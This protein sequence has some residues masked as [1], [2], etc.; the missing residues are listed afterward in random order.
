[1]SGPITLFTTLKPVVGHDAVT[2]RNA[3]ESWLALGSGRVRVIVMGGG[4]GVAELC[5]ELGVEH[6]EGV[7]VN[8]YGTPLLSGL[9]D[10]AEAQT[11]RGGVLC[12]LNADIALLP[13]FV[14]AVGRVGRAKKRYLMVGRRTNVRVSAE[15]TPDELE[16]LAKGAGSVDGPT[17]IDYFVTPKG[18]WGRLP[19]FAIGR[20]AWDNWMIYRARCLKM[21]VVDAT[22]CVLAIHQEHDYEHTDVEDGRGRKWVWQGPEARL[23]LTMAGGKR[24]LFT[25]MDATH[26]LTERGVE[27]CERGTGLGG[28]VWS[29][30]RSVSHPAVA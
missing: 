20:T 8:S 17:A 24:N 12:Y 1:M 6:V 9:Y 29:Y 16:A 18:A 22:A 2:Q 28:G 19:D 3:L 13:G 4:L 23:N 25:L 15:A 11:E 7:P 27:T 26:R 30:R 5:D 21:P 14:A 10:A